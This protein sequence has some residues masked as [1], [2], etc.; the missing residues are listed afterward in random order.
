[1]PSWM[2]PLQVWGLPH[3]A[4]RKRLFCLLP[5]QTGCWVRPC[6]EGEALYLTRKSDLSRLE[7]SQKGEARHWPG[8]ADSAPTGGLFMDVLTSPQALVFFRFHPPV[9]NT[10]FY[11]VFKSAR[12]L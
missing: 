3:V 8:G 1:M 2:L 5:G 10:C 7:H 4:K 12:A 9:F 11:L 6:V